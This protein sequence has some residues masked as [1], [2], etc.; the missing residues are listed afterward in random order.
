MIKRNGVQ[1]VAREAASTH[2][3]H[4][5]TAFEHASRYAIRVLAQQ[6]D[7]L[8][9]RIA[10]RDHKASAH[11]E[12]LDQ[13]CGNVGRSSRDEDGVKGRSFRPAATSVP[14]PHYD[15]RVL[16]PGEHVLSMARGPR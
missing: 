14:D 2:Q 3:R 6:P 16:Q 1:L 13:S 8:L 9:V 11:P 4:E 7:M 10:Y 5:T 12:L 15:L